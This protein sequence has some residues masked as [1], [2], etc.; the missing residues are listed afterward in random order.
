[1]NLKKT[2]IICCYYNEINILEKKFNKIISFSR[3]KKNLTFIFVDNNSTDGTKEFLKKIEQ[4]NYENF[5]FIYNNKNIGKGGSI[6]KAIQ[7]S[8]AEIIAI[9][10]VD[11]YSI[12]E[13]LKGIKIVSNSNIKLLIGS[14]LLKN[15]TFLYQANYFGVKFMTSIINIIYKINLTD[16][17]GATKIFYKK[18]YD[19]VKIYSNEFDFE[20]ELIC[21]FA[22]KNYLISEYKN[23]YKPRSYSEG[24]KIKAIKDG[25][26]ILKVILKSLIK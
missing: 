13:L 26:K 2:V 9:F 14:R 1:M 4:K 22:K 23:S 19:L 24:K 11:E 21:K 25:I 15:V 12:Y 10:D 8:D 3:E 16:A 20:F 7:S 17:A 5:K 18:N 6:K